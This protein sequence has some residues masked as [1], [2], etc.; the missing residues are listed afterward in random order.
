MNAENVWINYMDFKE[1]LSY[2]NKHSMSGN[3]GYGRLKK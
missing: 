2:K 1:P 3:G